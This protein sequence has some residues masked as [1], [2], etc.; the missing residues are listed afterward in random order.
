MTDKLVTDIGTLLKHLPP[1]HSIEFKTGYNLHENTIIQK[2][3]EK[4]VMEKGVRVKPVDYFK[5]LV[6]LSHLCGTM[7]Q[8]YKACD[9]LVTIS[10]AL[11]DQERAEGKDEGRSYMSLPAV[12]VEAGLDAQEIPRVLLT[13]RHKAEQQL[14]DIPTLA[15]ADPYYEAIGLCA[16]NL[17]LPE[18]RKYLEGLRSRVD[19][20]AVVFADCVGQTF[21][22]PRIYDAL[23]KRNYAAAAIAALDAMRTNASR[24]RLEEVIANG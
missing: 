7:G 22:D 13:R 10:K 24:Q 6:L 12:V 1:L 2:L 19:L 4:G 5:A 17:V 9:N 18:S 15:R 20:R 14:V 23:A 8:G 21:K 16:C 11:R 3:V